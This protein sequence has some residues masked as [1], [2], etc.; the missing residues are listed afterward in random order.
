MQLL[1]H[2]T[3]AYLYLTSHVDLLIDYIDYLFHESQFLVQLPDTRVRVPQNKETYVHC[4]LTG[5][6]DCDS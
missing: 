6:D 2:L 1:S 3:T 5:A 4:W